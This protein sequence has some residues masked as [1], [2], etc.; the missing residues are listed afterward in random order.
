MCKV[1]L[2]GHIVVPERELSIILKELEIHKNLTLKEQGCIVFE[3]TQSAAEVARFEVY[4]EF[5]NRA[6]FDYHQQRVAISHWGSVSKN[7]QRFYQI[8][9]EQ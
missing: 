4:E 1:I 3:V 6:A 5:I 2:K 8:V 9:E 7:V